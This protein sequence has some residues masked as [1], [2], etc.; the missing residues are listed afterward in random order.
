[1]RTFSKIFIVVLALWSAFLT[2]N[3]RAD[4]NPFSG[5]KNARELSQKANQEHFQVRFHYRPARTIS[6]FDTVGDMHVQGR[7]V[8][9]TW[10]NTFRMKNYIGKGISEVQKE[11]ANSNI[12]LQISYTP[13]TSDNYNRVYKQSIQPGQMISGIKTNNANNS[14]NANNYSS[15]NYSGFTGFKKP[16]LIKGGSHASSPYGHYETVHTGSRFGS[17]TKEVWVQTP[18]QSGGGNGQIKTSVAHDNSGNV[19][20]VLHVYK[21]TGKAQKM[22]DL[23]GLT[24]EEAKAKIKKAKLPIGYIQDTYKE[25]KNLD[26]N[27]YGKIFDQSIKAGTMIKKPQYIGVKIY[28][29][30]MPDLTKGWTLEK[31]SKIAYLG[32]IHLYVKTYDK[33][34]DG[35]ILEQSVKPGTVLLKKTLLTVKAYKYENPYYRADFIHLNKDVAIKKAVKRHLKYKI[36]NKDIFDFFHSTTLGSDFYK[37]HSNTVVD[38]TKDGETITFTIAKYTQKEEVMP[39]LVDKKCSDIV[40]P[41]YNLKQKIPGLTYKTEYIPELIFKKAGTVASTKPEAGKKIKTLD[42]VIIYCRRFSGNQK[43]AEAKIPDLRRKTQKEAVKTLNA[44]GFQKINIVKLNESGFVQGT[45]VSITGNTSYSAIDRKLYKNET[46][47]LY[48]ADSTAEEMF[49][50]PNV[51]GLSMEKAKDLLL[52]DG[53][54]QIKF[55]DEASSWVKYV[56]KLPSGSVIKSYPSYKGFIGHNDEIELIVRLKKGEKLLESIK[57]K[58][59]KNNTTTTVPVLQKN[60]ADTIKVLK[61][62]GLLAGRSNITLTANSSLDGTVELDSANPPFN[63]IVKKGSKVSFSVYTVNTNAPY[64]LGLSEKDA[65]SKLKKN[66]LTAKITY[67]TTTDTSKIDTVLSQNPSANSS[68]KCGSAIKLTI[69]KKADKFIKMPNIKMK[70]YGQDIVDLLS[71][72]YGLKSKVLGS[73]GT[74]DKD[75]D[76]KISSTQPD[77]GSS[78]PVGSTVNIFVYKFSTIRFPRF[79]FSKRISKPAVSKRKLV[80]LSSENDRKIRDFY[81]NFKEAYEAKDENS[82]ISFLASDWTSAS[83]GDLSDMEDNLNRTFRIFDEIEYRIANLNIQPIGG[84]RYR[85]SYNL[86]IIGQI[87]DNDITHEE[88]SSVQEDILIKNGKVEIEK[89]VGGQYWSIK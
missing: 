59:V 31:A 74:T 54:N 64:V 41:M 33:K 35:I 24:L 68:V 89:T 1:M 32:L 78:I 47:N 30:R 14:S 84:D 80:K 4:Y 45:V 28:S 38:V 73:A 76:G 29:V 10:Y 5:V 71:K 8:Y 66:L 51:V 40:E 23:K 49:L 88:K 65:I 34:K 81:K 27:S 18:A 20:L 46:I 53:F 42:N 48:I 21:Y 44:L 67:E 25:T 12:S 22:P 26:A 57:K 9:A 58:P 3:A 60:V 72:K 83:D 37:K 36:I 70:K 13:T 82:V 86:N 63:T 7:T 50:M 62:R 6:Q 61:E 85:V 19:L 87:Y 15:N 2:V 77:A 17:K 43:D 55:T 11:L 69:Y 39:N 79:R 16:S 75:K 56:S 52:A